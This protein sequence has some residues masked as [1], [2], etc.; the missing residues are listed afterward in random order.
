[1]E[2]DSADSSGDQSINLQEAGVIFIAAAVKSHFRGVD[3]ALGRGSIEVAETHLHRAFQ[4]GDVLI[5]NLKRRNND[6]KRWSSIES[7]L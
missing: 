6:I 1:M 5:D 3:L 2:E 4:V 7:E